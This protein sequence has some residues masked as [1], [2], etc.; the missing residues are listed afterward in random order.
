MTEIIKN[1]KDRTELTEKTGRPPCSA[2]SSPEIVRI[3]RAGEEEDRT[4]PKKSTPLPSPYKGGNGSGGK[5]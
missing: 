3:V 5:K 1:R 4:P 2:V